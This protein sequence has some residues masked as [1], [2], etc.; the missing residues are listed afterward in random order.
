MFTVSGDQ[1]LIATGTNFETLNDANNDGTYEL[2]TRVTDLGGATFDQTLEIILIDINET[3]ITTGDVAT[4]SENTDLVIDVTANDVDVDTS[5]IF[6]LSGFTTL[7]SGGTL[8]I[9]GSDAVYTPYTGFVGA[10]TFVYEVCDEA[11]SPED[12]VINEVYYLGTG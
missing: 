3:F 5:T 9:S 8:T 1:L 12:I 11:P 2:R 10:D 4:G 6:V 7:P